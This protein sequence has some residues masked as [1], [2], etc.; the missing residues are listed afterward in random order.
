MTA[1]DT[2]KTLTITK[3]HSGKRADVVLAES[4]AE[5]SRSQIKR[6]IDGG[7]VCLNEIPLKPSSKLSEGDTV[8]ITL[9]G[10]EP[11][12]LAPEDLGIELIYEDESIAVVNK[13][14]GM[15][16]H[17]GA[18]IKTGTLVNALLFTC[19]DLSGIGGKLRPGI[20]HRLDKDTSGVMVVAKSDTA[21]N[22]LTLQFKHREVK[23]KYLAIVLGNLKTD[24]GVIESQIGRH[25]TNR[26]KMSSQTKSGRDSVTIW[27]AIERYG[28]ST[29]VEAEP[30]TGRTHQIR[31]HF[32]ESGYPLLADKVYGFKKPKDDIVKRATKIMGRQALHARELGFKHPVTGEYVSFEAEVPGD[33]QK[34]I[35]FLKSSSY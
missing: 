11:I 30:K 29:L 28:R 9:P 15:T 13:P 8:L 1:N 12:D 35:E 19:K 17:P 10:P 5:L 33:M 24:A 2:S 20:V 23:K 34:A 32:S 21:H 3:E 27:R 18:G 22:S 26:V 25:T 7:G 16:V 6:L 4:L 14:P 31:V